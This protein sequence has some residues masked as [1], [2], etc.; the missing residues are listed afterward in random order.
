LKI[1]LETNRFMGKKGIK[2]ISLKCLGSFSL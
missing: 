2:E 1:M